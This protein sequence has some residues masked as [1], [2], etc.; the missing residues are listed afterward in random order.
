MSLM[1]AGQ[2]LSLFGSMQ[3]ASAQRRQAAR[4]AEQQEFN[5][6]LERIRGQQE[7]NDRLDAF[8]TYRSTANSIRGKT[9]RDVNDRSFKARVNAG[10][11]KSTEQI[12]RARVNSMFAENRMRY[13]AENTRRQ[14]AINANATMMAGM[15]NFAIG[16][17]KM[18]DIT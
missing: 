16:M 6:R 18:G 1:I 12:D 15:A 8:E 3:Q 17:D 4:I 7:H 13:Q 9:N 14:G 10:K 2:V 11:D 5:A